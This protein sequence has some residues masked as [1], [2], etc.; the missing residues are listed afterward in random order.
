M[1]VETLKIKPRAPQTR[2]IEKAQ[3]EGNPVPIAREPFEIQ[4][5][6]YSRADLVTFVENND[7]KVLDWIARL[8]N[9][10]VVSAIRS[11]LADDEQFPVD[12]EVD[13][14]N[15]DMEAIALDKLSEQTTKSNALELEFT[16]EQFSEFVHDFVASMLPQYQSVPKAEVKLLNIANVLIGGFK[17]IRNEQDKMDK[18][19][20]TL[21]KFATESSEEV[22]DKYAD[23]YEYFAAM[24]QKRSKALAKKNEKTDVFLD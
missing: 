15:F 4:I 11:Q 1:Q 14:S 13:I 5:P 24:Y 8:V 23:M 17:D 21:D 9:N 19:K 10:E 12:Q 3:K 7:Q 6:S 2:A 16:D 22:L 20:S 18:V